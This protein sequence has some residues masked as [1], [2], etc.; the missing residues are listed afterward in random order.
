MGNL[1]VLLSI[2]QSGTIQLSVMHLKHF[3]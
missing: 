2:I 1:D 3:R